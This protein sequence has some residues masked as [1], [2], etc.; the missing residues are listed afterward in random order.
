MSQRWI[1]LPSN[2]RL[3]VGW[4]RPLSTYFASLFPASDEQHDDEEEGATLFNTGCLGPVEFDDV[5]DFLEDLLDQLA[6]V[7]NNPQDLAALEL[8]EYLAL[9]R[10]TLLEDATRETVMHG[11]IHTSAILDL[12]TTS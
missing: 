12:I 7:S 6:A 3:L 10:V 4:D 1:H 5:D 8:P 9:V 11:P 2:R